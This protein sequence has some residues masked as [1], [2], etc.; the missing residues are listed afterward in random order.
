MTQPIPPQE[1]DA[2]RTLYLAGAHSEALGRA[3][4]RDPR[5]V[6]AALR[7]EGV[8]LR[9]EPPLPRIWDAGLPLPL[10]QALHAYL[11]QLQG[12]AQAAWARLDQVALETTASGQVF[13]SRDVYTAVLATTCPPESP[14]DV[15]RRL[16]LELTV[17]LLAAAEGLDTQE[18]LGETPVP[19]ME[20]VWH[21]SS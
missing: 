18:A 19:R 5:A 20:T 17:V 15:A 2:L 10:R 6:R 12:C 21:R 11:V 16:G 3:F 1:S 14:L 7:R 13:P 9:R 8:A 4:G